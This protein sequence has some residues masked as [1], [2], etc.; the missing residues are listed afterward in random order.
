MDNFFF[1]NQSSG[2]QIVES[3]VR[4]NTTSTI[5]PDP[6]VLDDAFTFEAWV[7]PV[8]TGATFA[9]DILTQR[10]GGSEACGLICIV[11]DN[12]TCDFG[13]ALYNGANTFALT[14]LN[15]PTDR[16][17]H[18]TYTYNSSNAIVYI[19]GVEV[20]N[21]AATSN[22]LTTAPLYLGGNNVGG[23]FFFNGDIGGY[24]VINN[25]VLTP[26]QIEDRYWGSIDIYNNPVASISNLSDWQ[27]HYTNTVFSLST[28]TIDGDAAYS[29]V[30]SGTGGTTFA[31]IREDF[32]TPLDLS[33]KM[34]R[35]R[36]TIDD[37]A[38]LDK[39][40]LLIQQGGALRTIDIS[41]LSSS[42]KLNDNQVIDS[43]ITP[44]VHTNQNISSVDK[45]YLRIKD[46]AAVATIHVHPEIEIYEL[47]TRGSVSI[48]ADDAHESIY[49]VGKP[50]LDSFGYNLA[51]APIPSNY[52][53]TDAPSPW[54]SIAQIDAAKASGWDIITHETDLRPLTPAERKT[55]LTEARDWMI[56]RGYT[57]WQDFVYPNGYNDNQL[58]ADLKE[59]SYTS[60]R[61]INKTNN[62]ARALSS[63]YQ[64]GSW[65]VSS[66]DSSNAVISEIDRTVN[67]GGHFVLTLHRITAGTEVNSTDWST[68]KLTAVL[69][70]LQNNG[71]RVERYVDFVNTIT[72]EAGR[73]TV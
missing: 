51:L 12:S 32:A 56:A 47:K 43:W 62:V 58:E 65:S 16:F 38:A 1:F 52:S 67:A 59:L 34:L 73:F 14:N 63:R 4:A 18:L 71:I 48:V 15:L 29:I 8:A 50:I 53:S 69:Q 45:L 3:F 30:S 17:Y 33:D 44:S 37:W 54:M 13:F 10:S 36:W 40:E 22:N 7:K 21:Q 31:G 66:G 23:D 19:N 11:R 6:G 72:K 5:L 68:T 46:N 70:H 64:I 41:N 35:V 24:Q 25:T 61:T 49:T 39:F 42:S 2:G 20:I 28:S 26:S 27:L 55:L 9:A 57:Q 60:A